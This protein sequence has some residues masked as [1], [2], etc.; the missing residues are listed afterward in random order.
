MPS[1]PPPLESY[2]VE[3]EISINA[4]MTRVWKALSAET[5]RWWPEHFYSH[6]DARNFIIENHV[7]G[8][9]YEDWG[10]GAGAEWGRVIVYQPPDK[11]VW[12][13]NVFGSGGND[14]GRYF[15]TITLK[16]DHHKTLLTL[17]DA[18]YGM[19]SK[20]MGNNLETG[21][22]ELFGKHFKKYAESAT[23]GRK[24]KKKTN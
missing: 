21:W 1:T 17:N 19:F 24:T 9:V 14:W 7:S 6:P 12:A 2:R 5:G 8:R 11:L 3:L 16:R 10:N 22:R 4:K 18:G 23:A 13:G 20:N 15:L